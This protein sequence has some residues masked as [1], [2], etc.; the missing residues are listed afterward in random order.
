[1]KLSLLILCVVMLLAGCGSTA[2]GRFRE[3]FQITR[4]DVRELTPESARKVLLRKI[5]QDTSEQRVYEV[6]KEAGIGSDGLSSFYPGTKENTIVCRIEYDPKTFG[7]V[8]ESYIISFLLD[9]QRRLKDIR[10][11]KWLTGP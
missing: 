8:K 3:Y 4:D 7:I 9:D 5:P 6:L 1:M 2:T 10:I 11:E